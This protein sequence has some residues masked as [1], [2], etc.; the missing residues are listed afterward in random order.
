MIEMENLS[1]EVAWEIAETIKNTVA[2]KGQGVCIT[3]VN[4]EGGVLI[5]YFMDRAKP[6]ARHVAS[7]K[8]R[9]SAY[10]GKRTSTTLEEIKE[11]KTTWHALGLKLR[12][13]AI[14]AGG[15]PIYSLE[16]ERLIGAV[17]VSGLSASEDEE[18]AIEGVESIEG[19][20]SDKP[21]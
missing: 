21:L 15:V 4:S 8:A 9:Q 3:V 2:S 5:T 16:E 1:S 17:G 6:V 14:W 7:V 19:L 20:I 12:E 11:E 10:T 13:R 18:V